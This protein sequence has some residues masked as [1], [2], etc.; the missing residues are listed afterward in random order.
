MV[1]GAYAMAAYGYVRATADLDI[2]VEA[3]EKNSENISKALLEFGAPSHL[4]DKNTLTKEGI[5]L[6]IG[7]SPSRIDIITGIDGVQFKEA[8]KKRK[9]VVLEGTKINVI[10]K[11]D[12][13]KNKLS[14]GREKDFLDAK[15]LQNNF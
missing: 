13:I 2:W 5:I 1:V 8:Y 11:Q 9:K 6:Q 3:D 12:L 10:S 7:V 14:T 4:Y 15:K